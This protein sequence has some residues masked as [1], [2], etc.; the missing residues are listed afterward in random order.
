MARSLTSSALSL[1][2]WPMR[3]RANW[4]GM[5]APSLLSNEA[6]TRTVPLLASTWLS[7]S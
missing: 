7:I 6:R 1:R 3:M 4:P 2:A 5:S